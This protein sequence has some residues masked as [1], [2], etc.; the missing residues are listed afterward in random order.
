MEIIFLPLHLL[1]LIFI[2]WNVFRADHMA[3]SWTR[4][5]VKTLDPVLVKKYHYRVWAG[6]ITMILTGL[7]LFYPERDYLLERPQFYAKMGFVL[8]IVINSIAIGFL[9][10]KAITHAYKDLRFTQ[11]LPLFISGVVSTLSWL[12]ATAGGFFLETD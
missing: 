4:G 6:L 9:Q 10:K 12:G 3:F 11:K 7:F 8:A 1:T 5:T 2:A